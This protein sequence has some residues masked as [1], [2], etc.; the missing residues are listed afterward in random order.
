MYARPGAE[1]CFSTTV[2]NVD[3][4]AKQGR[5]LHPWC[6]RMFSVREL[7]RSQG[8]PDD[9]V[10]KA[11]DDNVV[12]MHRQIGNAVPIPVARALGRELRDAL[13]K[14]WLARRAE[15]IVID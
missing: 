11:I 12:T 13:Y 10:F 5:V 1:E 4:T 3:P 14:K 15:A 2:T 6:H 9:F 8:F 7:A